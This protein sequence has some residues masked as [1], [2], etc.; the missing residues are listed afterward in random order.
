MALSTE[1]ILARKCVDRENFFASGEHTKKVLITRE[2]VASNA[3]AEATNTVHQNFRLPL[4]RPRRGWPAWADEEACPTV[5]IE[6]AAMAAIIRACNHGRLRIVT[7]RIWTLDHLNC[8]TLLPSVPARVFHVV[9]ENPG[10]EAGRLFPAKPVVVRSHQA[11]EGRAKGPTSVYGV[12]PKHTRVMSSAWDVAGGKLT[13]FLEDCPTR[14]R[15]VIRPTPGPLAWEGGGWSGSR[16]AHRQG[17]AR[18]S[19]RRSRI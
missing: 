3:V 10:G 13:D 18:R 7:R 6:P 8:T 11:S 9:I 19:R 5:G 15:P 1:S 4:A 16:R 2:A 12:G 14:R 17:Y